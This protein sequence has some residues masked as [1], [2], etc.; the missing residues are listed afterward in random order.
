MSQLS[1][2]SRRTVAFLA[3]LTLATACSQLGGLGSVLGSATQPQTGQVSS[4][5]EARRSAKRG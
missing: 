1:N 3:T 4:S 2:I 5:F